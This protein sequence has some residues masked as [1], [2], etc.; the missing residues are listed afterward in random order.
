MKRRA[1]TFVRLTLSEPLIMIWRYAARRGPTI[2][3][4][5]API[6][7]GVAVGRGVWSVVGVPTVEGALAVV[8]GITLGVDAL[9]F[10][11]CLGSATGGTT[12]SANER[13]G[14]ARSATSATKARRN[15]RA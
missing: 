8:C 3:A 2:A 1:V 7:A 5:G 9:G 13:R 11:A 12:Y 10:T 14:D 4:P 15:A 6:P